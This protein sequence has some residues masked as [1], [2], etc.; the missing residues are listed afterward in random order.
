MHIR[1]ACGE[2]LYSSHNSAPPLPASFLQTQ[3]RLAFLR[4]TTP[5]GRT[6]MRK[7]N[8]SGCFYYY[9]FGRTWPRQGMAVVCDRVE[10]ASG[11]RVSSE[12]CYQKINFAPY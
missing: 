3:V 12:H 6:S 11:V 10:S 8:D 1:Q 7:S 9:D 5:Q 2:R 4:H